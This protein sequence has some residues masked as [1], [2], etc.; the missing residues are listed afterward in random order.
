LAERIPGAARDR[1]PGGHELVW[2]EL[3][4]LGARFADG[5]RGFAVLVVDEWL[6][7]SRD[8]CSPVERVELLVGYLVELGESERAVRAALARAHD[9]ITP[10]G[11]DRMLAR[12]TAAASRRR[13]LTTHD[14]RRN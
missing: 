14:Q 4:G 13:R 3:R 12:R 1:F 9:R 5:R 8:D 2:P 7:L 6:E 10:A 11:H